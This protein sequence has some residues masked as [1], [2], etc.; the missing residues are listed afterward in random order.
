[1]LLTIEQKRRDPGIVVLEMKGRICL[2]RDCQEV[3]WVVND[4]LKK[5]EKK[6]I[7]DMGGIS[8]VDSTGIGI[9]VTCFGRLRKVGGE[10]RLA[11][12]QEK[13][14]EVLTITCVDR[15]IPL[16]STVDEAA[17]NF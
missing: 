1:M 7:F 8:L 11:A 12:V 6:I 14:R 16:Y 17:A 10:L 15:I 9:L 5:E 13:V 4:L 3:E 2:G